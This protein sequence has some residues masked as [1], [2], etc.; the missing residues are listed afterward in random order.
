MCKQRDHLWSHSCWHLKAQLEAA[1]LVC[2]RPKFTP[3]EAARFIG[4]GEP[5]WHHPGRFLCRKRP[6][7]REEVAGLRNVHA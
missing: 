5:S 3:Q 6:T 1:G 2:R 7:F 4:A